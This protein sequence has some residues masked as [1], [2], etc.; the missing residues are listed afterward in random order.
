M[1]QTLKCPEPGCEEMVEVWTSSNLITLAQRDR[2]RACPEH[3]EKY[4]KIL[5]ENERLRW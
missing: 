1:I 3:K 2:D 5:D 4:Q